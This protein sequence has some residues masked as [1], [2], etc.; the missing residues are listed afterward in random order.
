MITY[1]SNALIHVIPQNGSSHNFLPIIIII[2]QIIKYTAKSKHD[3]LNTSIYLTARYSQQEKII[4]DVFLMFYQNLSTWAKYRW[5]TLHYMYGKINCDRLLLKVS[6]G[7]MTIF[8]L[9]VDVERQFLQTR[10]TLNRSSKPKEKSLFQRKSCCFEDKSGSF[11][12]NIYF[13]NIGWNTLHT[14]MPYLCNS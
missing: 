14:C 6:H 7:W 3:G 1:K 12:K 8:G 13:T 5:R 4:D 2:S 10:S 11:M 9:T